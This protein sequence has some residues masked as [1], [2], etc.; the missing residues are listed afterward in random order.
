[1][2]RTIRRRS[3]SDHEKR[4]SRH[5][6]VGENS[7]WVAYTD[8]E[9]KSYSEYVQSRSQEFNRDWTRVAPR[10]NRAPKEYRARR[11]RQLRKIHE[12]ELRLDPDEISLT[13]FKH[14]AGWD[15]W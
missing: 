8:G 12:S 4:V 6:F 5:F 13:P 2:S 7:N 10:Y 11:N 15:Y 3:S 14:T 9:F 1:M